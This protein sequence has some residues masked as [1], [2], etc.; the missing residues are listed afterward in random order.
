MNHGFSSA[1]ID[2]CCLI[3]NLPI[4]KTVLKIVINIVLIEQEP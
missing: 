1:I 3:F 4:I 2:T